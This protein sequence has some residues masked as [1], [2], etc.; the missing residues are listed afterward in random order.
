MKPALEA[1]PSLPRDA[2]GP[3]FK[4]PWE[5]LA[6]S[7]AVKLHEQGLFSWKEWSECLGATIRDA[8]AAGDPDLGDT[9]Y[10]HWV[11]ALERLMIER[12]LADESG[13]AELAAG[14]A[15]DA[16]HHREL[17][18]KHSGKNS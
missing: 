15:D 11:K 9:Y 4:A 2:D 10:L 17:Q 3:V 8:Q 14:I 12:G 16:H 13:L 5:A 7:L 6:F 18:L 1:L